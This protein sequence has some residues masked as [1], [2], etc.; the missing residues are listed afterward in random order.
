MLVILSK[1][2]DAD[3]IGGWSRAAVASLLAI[4][5]AKFPGLSGVLDSAT[6]AAIGVAVSGI[7]VGIWSTSVKSDTAKVQMAADV[8][9][10]KAIQTTDPKIADATTAQVTLAK[11]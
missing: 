3:K 8:P 7:V 1:L 4:A 9:S 11:P 6:Q 5:I 10:T 2:I